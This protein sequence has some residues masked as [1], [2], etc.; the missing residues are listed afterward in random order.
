MARQSKTTQ[1]RKARA[2][3][4]R[5]GVRP[6]PVL[7]AVTLRAVTGGDGSANLFPPTPDPPLPVIV[8]G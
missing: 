3:E 7:S 5:S 8:R 2:Q 1:R 6:G 4:Q